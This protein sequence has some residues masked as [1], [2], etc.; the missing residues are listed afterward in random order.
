MTQCRKDTCG[1]CLFSG[2]H[3]CHS[4]LEFKT[5]NPYQKLEVPESDSTLHQLC[6]MAVEDRP[7]MCLLQTKFLVSLRWKR[8][9]QPFSWPCLENVTLYWK[10]ICSTCLSKE[11]MPFL[12]SKPPLPTR[13]LTFLRAAL[14]SASSALH[15]GFM[16]IPSLQLQKKDVCHADKQRVWSRSCGFQDLLQCS[17][18]ALS[19]AMRLLQTMANQ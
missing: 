4:F 9:C 2:I 10:D 3:S 18:C 12:K 8:G 16:P 13:R 15:Y 1:T 11:S 5:S 19:C 6:I 7:P 17:D 14:R